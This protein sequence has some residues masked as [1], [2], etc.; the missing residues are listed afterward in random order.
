MA[1]GVMSRTADSTKHGQTYSGERICG[2]KS[3]QLWSNFFFGSLLHCLAT[4]GIVFLGLCFL[5]SL[6]FLSVPLIQ[7]TSMSSIILSR[8]ILCDIIF[9]PAWWNSSY[10]SQM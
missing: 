5:A 1:I 6:Y 7:C 3:M 2:F 8:H 10:S 4:S 9:A